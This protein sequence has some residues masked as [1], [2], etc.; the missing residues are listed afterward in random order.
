M[1]VY[2]LCEVV[3]EKLG[4]IQYLQRD[5][6]LNSTV[7][8]VTCQH[9]CTLLQDRKKLSGNFW[10]CPKCR[11]KQ[12][13]LKDSFLERAKI[14]PAKFVYCVFYWAAQ[15]AVGTTVDHAGTVLP[16]SAR[17]LFME[18]VCQSHAVWW[19]RK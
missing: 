19:S 5:H 1:N 10:R 16:V 11:R 14:S 7:Q 12:S 13:V 3:K 17:H 4:V 15:I 2:E 18:V 9:P 6:I 8:C